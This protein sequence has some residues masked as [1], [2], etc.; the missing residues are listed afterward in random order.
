MKE[1]TLKKA[2]ELN[3]RLIKYKKSLKDVGY[4]Q[5]ENVVSRESYLNFNGIEDTVTVPASLFRT[6]GKLI[7]SEYIFEINKIK[8]QLDKL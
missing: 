4:T 2:N 8:D 5:S 7:Q 6:I 3:D 1:E